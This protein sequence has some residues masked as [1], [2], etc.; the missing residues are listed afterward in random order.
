MYYTGIDPLTMKPVYCAHDYEEKRMQRALLQYSR[1]DNAELVRRALEKCHRTD[2]IGYGPDCLARP[3][4]GNGGSR[5][6]RDAKS[7]KDV[8]SRSGQNQPSLR[9]SREASDRSRN[10]G[11]QKDSGRP[12]TKGGRA[13]NKSQAFSGKKAQ[14]SNDKN[15]GGYPHR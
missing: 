1:P 9:V 3:R 4:S 5:S 15:R 7:N 13:D 2:L 10:R 14:A 12:I 8:K 6:Q 11:H